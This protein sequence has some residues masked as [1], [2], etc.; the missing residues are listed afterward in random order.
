[1]AGL[2]LKQIKKAINE[3]VIAKYPEIPVM[4]NDVK[5]GF[6]RP[7]FF[8]QMEDVT[9]DN[10]LYV[11]ERSMTVRIYF[12][13]KDRNKPNAEMLDK[14]DGLQEVFD[15]NIKVED[16]SITINETNAD[17]ADGVLHFDFSF[18]YLE[19]RLKEPTEPLMA[20]I[21]YGDGV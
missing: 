7:S 17:T 14:I 10:R 1:M 13:P 4:S 21:E 8:V 18:M 11:S 9:A 3:A 12:F 5:E 6:P 19:S 15:L 20:E 16:R 2:T